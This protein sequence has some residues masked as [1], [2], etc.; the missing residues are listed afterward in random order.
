MIMK[1]KQ[2]ARAQLKSGW[3]MFALI[4]FALATPVYSQPAADFTLTV[5]NKLEAIALQP[6]GKILVLGA[7][8]NLGGKPCQPICR[9]NQDGSV[10]GTFNFTPIRYYRA[11]LQ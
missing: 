5:S 3:M 7:L 4:V 1:S 8:N 2:Q 9:L 6:D 10:D 11:R